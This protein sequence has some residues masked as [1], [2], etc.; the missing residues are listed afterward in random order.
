MANS[1]IAFS[2]LGGRGAFIGCVGDDR[3]GLFYKTEFDELDID[4]G[5]PV[6]VGETTG[7][8]LSLV[9]P[10]AERTMRTCLAVSSHLADRHVDERTHP[11]F[12][13]A[14]RRGLRVRQPGDRP[15]GDPRGGRLAKRHGTKVA[16]TCS[17]A[18]VV[19]VFG[20]AFRPHLARPSVVLQRY[21]GV[22]VTGRRRGRGL[23]RGSRSGAVGRRHRRAHGAFVRYDGVE[24]HVPAFPCQP[25]I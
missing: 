21:R 3:Y 9:T 12:G 2:Q 23:S 11:R 15:G 4:F 20:D 8:C 6:I 22:A 7:T 10:D 14:V 18:F 1:I 5:N 19:H 16:I 13:M 24:A 25:G 17:E